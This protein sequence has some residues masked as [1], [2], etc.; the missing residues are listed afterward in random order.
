MHHVSLGGIAGLVVDGTDVYPAA[1]V[2]HPHGCH[3]I[4]DS[5]NPPNRETDAQ[6]HYDDKV[7]GG[8]KRGRERSRR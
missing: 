8:R 6:N 7:H 3:L 4:R 2:P 1:T 5:S